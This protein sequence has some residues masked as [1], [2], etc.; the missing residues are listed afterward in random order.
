MNVEGTV[1]V[2]FFIVLLLMIGAGYS[3][4]LLD[5]DAKKVDGV[6]KQAGSRSETE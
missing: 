5:Q 6:R 3:Y 4:Y 1:T 2:V